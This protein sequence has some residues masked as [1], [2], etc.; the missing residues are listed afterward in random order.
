M[1]TV[2]FR[3]NWLC[4]LRWWPRAALTAISA[5]LFCA[6]LDVKQA[7]PGERAATS[8]LRSPTP[9]GSRDYSSRDATCDAVA[10]LTRSHDAARELVCGFRLVDRQVGINFFRAGAF[11]DTSALI[12][13][14]RRRLR[15]QQC[16]GCLSLDSALPTSSGNISFALTVPLMASALFQS[17]SLN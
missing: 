8:L 1:S 2:V 13:S 9:S 7:W 12:T 16:S 3:C 14:W 15:W 11:V 10:D 6:S 5:G 4:R 17:Q